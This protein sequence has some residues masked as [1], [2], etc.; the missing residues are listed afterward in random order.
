MSD[1]KKLYVAKLNPTKTTNATLRRCFSN[2]GELVDCKVV[3]D[4]NTR[5]SRGFGYVTFRNVADAEQALLEMNQQELDDAVITVEV[6]KDQTNAFAPFRHS[7]L[8]IPAGAAAAAALGPITYPEQPFDNANKTVF[9][10]LCERLDAIGRAKGSIAKTSLLF[11]EQ[12]VK[13]LQG[14]SWY[15]VLR[16]V[17]PEFDRERSKYHVKAQALGKLLVNAMQGQGRDFANRLLNWK[18][19][20]RANGGVVGDF[21]NVLK[22]VLVERQVSTQP[23]AVRLTVGE[24]NALL[25]RLSLATGTDDRQQVINELLAKCSVLEICWFTKIV[26]KDLNCGLHHGAVLKRYHPDAIQ[27]MENHGDLRKCLAELSDP[28]VRHEFKVELFSV[29]SPMLAR[30]TRM[31]QATIGMGDFVIENKYD[32]DRMLIHI[33]KTQFPPQIKLFT[34]NGTDYTA[35]YGSPLLFGQLLQ[36]VRCERCILDGEM[37]AWDDNLD[38]M[39]DFGQTTTVAM[40]MNSPQYDGKRWLLYMCF[41]ALLIEDGRGGNAILTQEPLRTRRARLKSI[42]TPIDRRIEIAEAL[43]VVTT[44]DLESRHQLV[45]QELDKVILTKGEGL[46]LKA[47]SS[48]YVGGETG[49]NLGH[50]VKVKPEHV[51]GLAE[52]LDMVVLG[53][54]YPDSKRRV[55][56]LGDPS[57]FL[58]GVPSPTQPGRFLSTVKVGTGYSLLQLKELRE[59][60]RPH[61]VRT[62]PQTMPPH[63]T[64]PAKRLDLPDVWLAP[65]HSVVLQVTGSELVPSDAFEA[66]YTLRFPRVSRIRYDKSVSECTSFAEL[67]RLAVDFATAAVGVDSGKGGGLHGAKRAADINRLDAHR[68]A[69]LSTK[70]KRLHTQVLGLGGTRH[71]TDIAVTSR[72]LQVNMFYVFP[73]TTCE[74]LDSKQQ[75]EVFITQHGGGVV[76]VPS[77]KHELFLIA[78]AEV[79]R[80]PTQQL[81]NLKSS[82][83]LNVMRVEFVVDFVNNYSPVDGDGLAS[84]A[85]FE[86]YLV[87]SDATRKSME[88]ELDEFGDHFEQD[89]DLYSLERCMLGVKPPFTIPNQVVY[90]QLLDD[91]DDPLATPFN[92]FRGLVAWSP[93]PDACELEALVLRMHGGRMATE[94]G[95][96]V[97]HVFFYGASSVPVAATKQAWQNLPCRDPAPVGA[98]WNGGI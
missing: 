12:W 78:S 81:R 26:L 35:R 72:A 54:Y 2:Y 73:Q 53:G 75:V 64:V 40:E 96:D 28:N 4:P 19:P 8:S 39:L 56:D 49:R 25:D 9:F 88:H 68:H 29:T 36:A 90:K 16:L 51:N 13:Y 59:K 10:T 17:L 27:A 50:W 94:L 89:A 31:D 86:D 46:I 11:D 21:C 41:D 67:R 84:H 69:N 7:R 97:T 76:Q 5:A 91:A 33:D 32:G 95:P 92:L 14:Q 79:M 52:E 23:L 62:T 77:G 60:L 74:G 20:E 37:L 30:I 15:P 6:A 47:L 55:N 61:L 18:D 82:G 34:R 45:M 85:R 3:L 83:K 87:M 57:V 80:H 93:D 24:V 65:S 63:F 70:R 43:Q 44:M 38:G 42:F 66:G 58:L 22:E 48:P 71:L 98:L 1:R